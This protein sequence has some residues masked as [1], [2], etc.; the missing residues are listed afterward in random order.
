MIERQ[1]DLSALGPPGR[2]DHRYAIDP[3]VP[4]LAWALGLERD[5]RIAVVGFGYVVRK[6][7]LAGEMAIL[8]H[9]FRS[10]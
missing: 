4:R 9:R 5:R 8:T 3:L 10:G 2:R 6:I 1:K 7:D